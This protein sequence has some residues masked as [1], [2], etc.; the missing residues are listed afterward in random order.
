VYDGCSV[1]V[2]VPGYNEEGLIGEVIDGVPPFV[3]ALYV[4]D[5]HSTDGTWEEIKRA[6]SDAPADA[7]PTPDGGRNSATRV[8]TFRHR[9]NRGRGGAVKTGYRAA[10]SDGM[11]VVAVMDGDGQMDPEI[12]DEIVDPVVGDEVDYVVGDR[13]GERTLRAEMPRFRLFGNLLLTLLTR[14][15][16]GHWSVSDP[17]NGYTAISRRALAALDIDA[18]YD[19][20]GFL[21]DLLVRLNVHGFRVVNVPM[22]ARYGEEESGIHYS[23]FIPKLSLLLCRLLLY[24]LVVSRVWTPDGRDRTDP[25]HDPYP[26]G[27]ESAVGLEV[28]EPPERVDEL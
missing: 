15:A 23:T 2:V 9:R 4:V 8:V 16:S 25:G 1:G 18:L 11:D 13:L 5:D 20:Y 19:D 28:E 12:L 14:V 24:R 17:Q 22:C 6:T 27:D 3:D 26:V 21:N 7:V 10:L